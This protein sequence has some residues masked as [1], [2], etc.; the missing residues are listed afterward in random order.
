MK[1]N[2]NKTD[3]SRAECLDFSTHASLK[4]ATRRFRCASLARRQVDIVSL[5]NVNC[6]RLQVVFPINHDMLINRRPLVIVDKRQ[7]RMIYSSWPDC[8]DCTLIV[9]EIDSNRGCAI[10]STQLDWLGLQHVLM[11]PTL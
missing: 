7:H 5:K 1:T 4:F 11:V 2:N 6:I 9:T 8:I 10:C 3:A